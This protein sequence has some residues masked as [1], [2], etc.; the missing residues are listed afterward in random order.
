MSIWTAP[1]TWTRPFASADNAKTQRYSP[2]NT[3]E[4]LLVHDTYRRPR[5]AAAGHLPR[6]GRGGCAATPPRALLGGDVLAA[7]EDDWYAE[8]NAPIL[9]IRIVDS[10]D[11]AI[12]TSTSTA[13]STDAIITENFSDAWRFLTEV[14]S[15]S[16]MVNHLDPFRRRFREY[17]LGRRSASPPTSCMPA[18]R[19]AWKA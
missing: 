10:L 1:P 5:A 15:A 19:S 7:S 6:Q 16:V 3:M 9:A 13:R 4:T 18:A 14:D 8:Y 11:A 17:G 2:C 12:G